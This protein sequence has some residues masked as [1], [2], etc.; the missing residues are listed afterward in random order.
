MPDIFRCPVSFPGIPTTGGAVYANDGTTLAV[1][2]AGTSGQVLTSNGAAAPTWQT[3]AAGGITELTGDGA[4]GPGSGSQVF[5]LP[6]TG[7]AAGSYTNTN[8]TVDAKGRITAASN[9][10]AGSSGLILVEKQTITS[11]Q[12]DVTFS[13]LDGDTDEVYLLIGRIVIPSAGSAPIFTW[14]PNGITTNQSCQWGY[15]GGILA[16]GSASNLTLSDQSSPGSF[17]TFEVT[18]HAKKNPNSVA[19]RRVYTGMFFARYSSDTIS[20]P[21]FVGG[22]WAETS[23]NITSLVIH[24]SVASKIGDGSTLALYRYA[25]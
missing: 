23:T 8:L 13:G 22:Q 18:I 24:S 17:T 4:A 20:S 19:A 16:S 9:G 12:T 6:S 5:T 2:A 11:A 3:P 15:V 25:Q 21:A 1:T 10:S 14:Q 7:V